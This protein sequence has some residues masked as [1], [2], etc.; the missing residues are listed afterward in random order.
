MPKDIFDFAQQGDLE[1]VKHF[2][3]TLGFDVGT[4]QCKVL[5]VA[6]ERRHLDIVDFLLQQPNADTTYCN[7][8]CLKSAAEL[9]DFDL[10]F[11]LLNH[12]STIITLSD[13]FLVDKAGFTCSIPLTM[14]IINNTILDLSIHKNLLISEIY[15]SGFFHTSLLIW[16]S[17][18]VK[19]TLEQDNKPIYNKIVELE[20][21][22]NKITSF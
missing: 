5:R 8:F 17:K 15:N 4:D 16:Q 6:V 12:H 13:K 22:Q 21:F 3:N 1:M 10:L 14:Y 9:S 2:V 18:N 11:K 19:L 20:L 7:N